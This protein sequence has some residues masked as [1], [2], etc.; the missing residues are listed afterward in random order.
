M[1]TVNL[2]CV[3]SRLHLEH[4]G[5]LHK[6][7]EV[8][9]FDMYIASFSQTAFSVQGVADLQYVANDKQPSVVT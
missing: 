1:I 3:Q 2:S 6:L 8:K 4:T 5:L 7:F 9:F